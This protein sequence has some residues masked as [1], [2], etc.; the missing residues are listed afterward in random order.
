MNKFVKNRN[1]YTLRFSYIPPQF[2]ER[3][4][5]TDEI[6]GNFT[7]E[8]PTY[9]CVFITGVRGAGKTVMMN[10]I[11][12]KIDS[13]KDWVTVDLNPESNLLESLAHMLYQIP[14][15]RPLFVKAKLDLSMPGIGV[16]IEKA[17]NY[18][19]GDEDAVCKMLKVLKK[20]GKKLL[21]TIDEITYSEDVAR[22]SHALSS[23]AGLGLDVYVLMTGL[24]ENIDNIKNK[25]SLTFLYRAKI[26]TLQNLNRVAMSFNYRDTLELDMDEAR[27]LA[28]KSKGYSFAFQAIG[29]HFWN[30]KS[31]QKNKEKRIDHK[32]LDEE[33]DGTLFDMAYEKIW[34]ELSHKDRMILV[35]MQK[36]RNRSGKELIRVE[37]IRKEMDMSSDTFTT[38]RKRLIDSGIVNGEKYGYLDLC[39]PRF[40]EY[41]SQTQEFRDSEEKSSPEV[42]LMMDFRDLTEDKQ[43]RLL[44]YMEKLKSC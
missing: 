21:I 25:K 13:Y 4:A 7:M 16:S 43:K 42:Q 23:Y 18:A 44:A 24:K 3:T 17:D 41:I 2:I 15:I 8:L 33:L 28:D 32:L 10:D 39:L 37:E 38:Y 29:Y 31:E 34:D 1:P 40:G 6:M 19:A 36:L 20:S 14:E 35:A 5:I 22:F 11:R 26:Y 9:G 30:L 27:C 12:N